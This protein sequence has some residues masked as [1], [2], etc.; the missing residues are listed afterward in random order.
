MAHS[1]GQTIRKLRKERNLTQEEL[2]EQLNVTAKAV[3]KWENETGL[4]DISQVVPLANVF[5]VPTDILFGTA[6]LDPDAEVERIIN[7][8]SAL[9]RLTYETDEAEQ[10]PHGFTNEHGLMQAWIRRAAGDTDGEI[11]ARCNNIAR[12]LDTLADEIGPLG[13]AYADKGQYEDAYRVF[14]TL[15]DLLPV[16]Y[17]DEPYTPLMHTL[18]ASGI[19]YCCLKLGQ[20]DEAVE[21]FW[22]DFDHLCRNAENYNREEPLE[23]PLLRACKFRYFGEAMSVKQHMEYIHY[24]RF[25]PLFDYPRYRELAEKLESMP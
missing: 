18:H 10:M 2:A 13:W 24:K 17:G 3:S 22:R 4:P 1:I 15:F 5:G 21:W 20:P 23:T 16:L 14:R 7:E 8:A 19:A 25:K 9:R 11:E 6:N 12:L